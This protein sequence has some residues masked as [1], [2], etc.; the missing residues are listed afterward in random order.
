[1][2]NPHYRYICS[3]VLALWVLLVSTTGAG[4]EMERCDFFPATPLSPRR[5]VIRLRRPSRKAAT[6]CSRSGRTTVPTSP[7]D[8]KAKRRRTFMAC[9]S[10]RR[11]ICS[12]PSRSH[13]GRA[14]AQDNPKVVWNGTHW[15]VVFESTNSRRRV[16]P[17]S[18]WRLCASRRPVT[19]L[20]ARP[21]FLNG[22]T[23]LG[24]VYWAAAS[25]GANWVVVKPGHFHGGNIV[26]M[27]ISADGV[28]L[29]P[30]TRA[31]VKATYYNRSKPESGL[32]GRGLLLAFNDS[33]DT[34]ASASTATLTCLMPHL[35]RYSIRH[36]RAS[37]ARN[38]FYIVWHRQ[39]AD[40]SVNVAGSR[41][42]TAARNSTA[43]ASTSQARRPPMPTRPRPLS[44]TA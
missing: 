37:P 13:H 12:T 5:P 27:R 17:R 23:P 36:C 28:V 32:F 26:A 21:I 10:T 31:L 4:A 22:L 41:V 8:S 24:S 43:T 16:L 2:N 1:M 44:G 19:L 33:D 38:R 3:A 15:L 35:W 6:S 39:N 14:L 29:D 7:A 34:K 42:S 25:D 20:D 40:Y 30:P 9:V 11:A 18:R